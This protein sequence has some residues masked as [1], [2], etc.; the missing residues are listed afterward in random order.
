MA[1]VYLIPSLL[2]EEGIN[3]IPLYIIDAVKNCQVFFV[4]NERTARRYLKRIWKARLTDGQEI[5]IDNYEWHNMSDTL[6]LSDMFKQNNPNKGS[7][8]LRASGTLDI[9]KQK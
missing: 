4:E 8:G 9:F 7:G 6:K 5:V 1:R 3:A 2:H